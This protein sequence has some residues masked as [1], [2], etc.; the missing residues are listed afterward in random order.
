MQADQ[1][2]PHALIRI[3]LSDKGYYLLEPAND[4]FDR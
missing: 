1:T 3:L 2:T 4:Y